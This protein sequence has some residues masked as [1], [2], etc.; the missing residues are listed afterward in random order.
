MLKEKLNRSLL[1]LFAEPDTDPNADPE[2]NKDPEPDKDPEPNNDPKPAAKYSDEDLDRIIGEK[3]AKWQAKKEKEIDEAKK[4]AEM[5]AQQKAEYERDQLQKEI[6]DLKAQKAKAQLSKEARKML[7]EKNITVNDDLLAC[8]V[9][10]NAEDTK[11]AIDSFADLYTKAVNKGVKDALKGSAPKGGGG[12]K[13]VVTKEDIYAIKDPV[14]RQ[15]MIA[16]NM[17]LFK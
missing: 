10:G 5:N 2:P 3:F 12:G 9:R 16:E 6:D 4:L 11:V 14:E 8:L 7:G 17:D 13:N 1:Q 15:R